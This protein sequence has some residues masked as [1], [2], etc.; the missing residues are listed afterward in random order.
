MEYPEILR[1]A[2][3][4]KAAGWKPQDLKKASAAITE[5]YKNNIGNGNSLVVSDIDSVVYS[6]VRMP[7]TFSAIRRSLEWASERTDE[8]NK[9]RSVLDVGAGTGAAAWTMLGMLDR[10]N[11]IVCLE[12]EESMLTLGKALMSSC[13][14]LEKK[15][16]WLRQDINTFSSE[17]K[18]DLVI[19]SY[20]LNELTPSDREKAVKSLWEKS[21]KMLVL[22]EP[23][24]PAGFSYIKMAREILLS[25]G[26]HIAAPCPHEEK[27]RMDKDDWCHFTVR[28]QRS[29][30]HK[31]LKSADVPYEDEKFSYA[32][33]IRE[34]VADKCSRILRH[35]YIEKS[36][37]TL[38]LCGTEDNQTAVITKKQGVLF[39]AAKKSKCG[40]S[41]VI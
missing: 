14:E 39:K 25:C 5:R 3:E 22:I 11:E 21:S 2:V 18:Y 15:T 36:K 35:P 31:M 13:P 6:I 27:C 40:D 12:R 23:G 32:V 24:T 16:E 20:M 33:F 1:N 41:I 7:A 29:R 8:I 4:L 17:K 26:A 10:I 37:I 28:I 9:V 34:G 30:L 19:A 38:E